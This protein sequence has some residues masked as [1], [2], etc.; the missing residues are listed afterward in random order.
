M[1]KVT[2]HN[3]DMVVLNIYAPNNIITDFLRQKL[4]KTETYFT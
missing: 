3:E 1:L 4:K 2:I